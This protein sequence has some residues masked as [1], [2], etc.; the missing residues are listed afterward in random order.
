MFFLLR[1]LQNCGG[2]LGLPASFA[3]ID[4]IIQLRIEK[5]KSPNRFRNFFA[6]PAGN[7][8]VQHPK[9]KFQKCQ[10]SIIIIKI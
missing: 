5:N 1:F 4:Y 9:C 6:S 7:F 8:P 10:L 2:K 3:I